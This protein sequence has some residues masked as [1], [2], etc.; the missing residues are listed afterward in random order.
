V[1]YK[2]QI[3]LTSSRKRLECMYTSSR[4]WEG[5]IWRMEER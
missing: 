1:N 2:K 3:F 4:N 5:H